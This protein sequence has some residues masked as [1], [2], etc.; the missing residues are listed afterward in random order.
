MSHSSPPR[1]AVKP[2]KRQLDASERSTAG[3]VPWAW[4][5]KRVLR[6]IRKAFDSQNAVA[7]ALAVY[8]A[9]TEIASDEAVDEFTT[10]VPHVAHRAGLS[11]RTTGKR[12]ADLARLG[13]LAVQTP[14]LKAPS[15]YALLPFDSHSPTTG[16]G[17]RTISNGCATTGN[18]C[19]A[20]GKR[21]APRLRTV[22]EIEGINGQSVG[23]E[24]PVELPTGFPATVDEA[25]MAA[26]FAG[27]PEDFAGLTWNKAMSRGGMDAKGQPIRS[28]RHYLATEWQF[29]Q[30]RAATHPQPRQRTAPDHSKGF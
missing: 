30:N 24:R 14:K 26:L 13:V 19:R 6:K 10:T 17:C 25:K 21:E 22:E 20:F 8:H 29:Q 2:E 4:Q 9:L 3:A 28:W 15:T 27:V 7:S 16:N 18:G 5:D 23:A 12:I 11:P 1:P